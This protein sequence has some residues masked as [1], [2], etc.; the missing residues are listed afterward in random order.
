MLDKISSLCDELKMYFIDLG[1]PIAPPTCLQS[2]KLKQINVGLIHICQG[3]FGCY[4]SLFQ[5]AMKLYTY[6]TGL[7]YSVTNI[8]QLLQIL[9]MLC[10]YLARYFS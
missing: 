4:D 2:N 8:K 10:N 5:N 3:I 6:S 9:T 1:F 7:F